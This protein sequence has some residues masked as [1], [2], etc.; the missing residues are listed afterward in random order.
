MFPKFL[1]NTLLPVAGASGWPHDRCQITKIEQQQV[2]AASPAACMFFDYILLCVFLTRERSWTGA[3]NGIAE[4][5]GTSTS[6]R[7]PW[8]FPSF[9]PQPHRGTVTKRRE[10]REG[11]T[12][13]SGTAEM[14]TNRE[15][16]RT[17]RKSDPVMERKAWIWFSLGQFD[18]QH[19]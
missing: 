15:K 12:S 6:I 19:T 10:Q 11:E 7:F 5:C 4:L 16:K 14:V 2:A 13:I 18:H 1:N 17:D 9:D 3:R 8:P